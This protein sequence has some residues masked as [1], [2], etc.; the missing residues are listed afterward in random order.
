[1]IK[2]F[3]RTPQELKAFR[4]AVTYFKKAGYDEHEAEQAAWDI[5]HAAR[6]GKQMVA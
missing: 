1:M 2:Y 6:R 3:R 4:E 5:F